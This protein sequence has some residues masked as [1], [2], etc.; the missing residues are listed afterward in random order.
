MATE[1]VAQKWSVKKMVRL[2][3]TSAT[4]K[5][6]S[7]VTPEMHERDQYNKLLARGPRFRLEGEMIR[8]VG[9]TASGLLNPKIGGPSVFPYQPEGIWSIPYNDDYWKM[10][11]GSERYR[12]GLYT[13]WRRTSPYPSLT[14]FDATSREFCTVRRVRTNTRVAGA[15]HA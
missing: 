6:D 11:E 4:Y 10:S 5:Q 12:R 2:M 14:T 1:F 13:F 8:D 3:V 9:L 7:R 15:H